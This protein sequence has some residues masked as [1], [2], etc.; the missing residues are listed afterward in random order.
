MELSPIRYMSAVVAALAA[1]FAA[2]AVASAQPAIHPAAGAV[3]PQHPEVSLCTDTST[4]RTATVKGVNQYG[5]LVT[6]PYVNLTPGPN[7]AVVAGYWWNMGNPNI[8]IDV[9]DSYN[10]TQPP[11]WR[12]L[13]YCSWDGR[14]GKNL[15]YCRF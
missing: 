8:E 11:I 15:R 9:T 13:N 4:F 14:P 2:P 5:Q 7:C 1:V 6:S 12:N 3:D 10:V